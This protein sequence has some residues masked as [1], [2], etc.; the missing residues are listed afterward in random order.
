MYATIARTA[1][2]AFMA[3]LGLWLI[4]TSR[5]LD[6][7]LARRAKSRDDSAALDAMSERELRDIGL[8]PARARPAEWTRDWRL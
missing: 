8:D 6:A 7:W 3:G 5:T 4:R 1:P 2:A